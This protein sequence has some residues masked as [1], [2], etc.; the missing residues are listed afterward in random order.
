MM[1]CCGCP[2]NKLNEYNHWQP[3]ANSNF[4]PTANEEARFAHAACYSRDA[5]SDAIQG[6]AMLLSTEYL[7]LISCVHIVETGIISING[8]GVHEPSTIVT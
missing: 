3:Q 5:I 2:N 8:E 4:L 1:Q 6:S 7:S